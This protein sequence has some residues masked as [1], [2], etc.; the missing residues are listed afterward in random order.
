MRTQIQTIHSLLLVNAAHPIP[1]STAHLDLVCVDARWPEVQLERR[2]AGLLNACIQAVGGQDLIVPVSGWR[3]QRE[4][5]AIWDDTLA[6]EGEDFTRK[7]VALPGCS[8][9][10]TGL[11]IDLGAA[12]KEIDFIRP[13]FPYDGVCGAFRQ[14]AADY[15]FVLR[16]PAGKEAVT[17]IAHEPWH[18]RYVGVPHARLMT[19][20]G[21]TLEE[22]VALLR[23]DYA[24][25]PLTFQSGSRTFQIQYHSGAAC[26]EDVPEAGGYRQVSADNC[27][28]FVVTLW[29]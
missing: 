10:Q 17:G 27:G 16:Y 24:Q 28:G 6:K 21:L 4:Q 7:Y 23:R 20:L 18:F 19:D 2:A 1:A 14:R 13:E 11:A 12:A 25:R 8:E 22:Y 3:S 15:G 9:H 26:R 5:Q 29:R